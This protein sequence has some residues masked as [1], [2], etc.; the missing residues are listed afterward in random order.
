MNPVVSTGNAST[1]GVRKT[2]AK[3]NGAESAESDKSGGFAEQLKQSENMADLV[4]WSTAGAA[5]IPVQKAETNAVEKPANAPQNGQSALG[6]EAVS[7]SAGPLPAELKQIGQAGNDLSKI[8]SSG[9]G[10]EMASTNSLANQI[11][12]P[13]GK[14]GAAALTGQDAATAKSVPSGLESRI[15]QLNGSVQAVDPA[16]SMLGALS[17][18]GALPGELDPESAPQASVSRAGLSGGEYLAAL[19]GAR[20]SGAET[21]A[22]EFGGKLD[23]AWDNPRVTARMKA[24]GA[25][26]SSTLNAGGKPALGEGMTVAESAAFADGLTS[27]RMLTGEKRLR[28]STL[29]LSPDGA[30]HMANPALNGARVERSIAPP[31]V[32]VTG[33]V[34]Q[35]A[36]AKDR[37]SSESMIGLSNGIGSVA[38]RG[39]GE[40]RIRLRPDNLGELSVHVATVDNRVGLRIQ[41]TDPS[42]KQVIEESVKYLRDSLAQQNLSLAKVEVT[43]AHAAAHSSGPNLHGSN[44]AMANGN[45]S[46]QPD[47]SQFAG[48]NAFDPM[49]GGSSGYRQDQGYGGNDSSVRDYREAS[50]YASGSSAHGAQGLRAGPYSRTSQSDRRLD[51]MA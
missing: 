5:Q 45:T 20:E 36:W 15:A 51:V 6:A 41:A 7:K 29:P 26:G 14:A 48:Q 8:G 21:G 37:L 24:G 38:N 40:I 2:S 1:G 12:K 19:D 39:G 32:E 9:S 22:T 4:Q 27:E 31:P 34:V 28:P 47:F 3:A 44:L 35:G 25:N 46:G 11:G 43:L 30:Q 23:R 49:G 42:A 33:H 16:D 50:P 17:A 13:S 18:E 10:L